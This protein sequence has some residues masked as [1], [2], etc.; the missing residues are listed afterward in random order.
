MPSA[1]GRAPER[2]GGGEQLRT[3]IHWLLSLSCARRRKCPL[4]A[5]TGSIAASARRLCPRAL[6][7]AEVEIRTYTD[8]YPNDRKVP[9]QVWI[10]E[11]AARGWVILTKDKN[12]RR[13][14]IEIQALR[15]PNA[16]YVCL[17]ATN[18]RGEEQAACLLHHWKTIDSVVANKPV[19]L[20]VTVSREKV[21]WLDGSTWRTAKR[22]R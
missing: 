6:R 17:S 2:A 19:P 10:P 9:D 4:R 3:N 21:L 14:P 7:A 16:R 5:P 8:L 1:V 18:M 12:I 15:L 11:V 20:I 13:A 22:K